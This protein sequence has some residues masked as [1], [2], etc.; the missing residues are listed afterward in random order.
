[1]RH[2]RRNIL[3]KNTYIFIY[4][5]AHVRTGAFRVVLEDGSHDN[6]EGRAKLTTT[7]LSTGPGKLKKTVVTTV[8]RAVQTYGVVSHNSV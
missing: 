4:I 7:V 3:I 8:F 6:V 2:Q 5:E 1:M